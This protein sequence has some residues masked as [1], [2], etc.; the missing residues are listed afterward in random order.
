MILTKENNLKE[1]TVIHVYSS[2]QKKISRLEIAEKCCF[3]SN[4][5]TTKEIRRQN[6]LFTKENKIMHLFETLRKLT[7]MFIQ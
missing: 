2:M 1:I 4:T 7:I 3:K 5:F 6:N